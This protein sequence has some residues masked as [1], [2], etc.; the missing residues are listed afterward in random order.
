MNNPV[1]KDDVEVCDILRVFSGDGP[2]R[3]WESGQQRGGNFPCICG[4]KATEYGNLVHCYRHE[5]LD[6]DDRRN[7]VVSSESLK[8]IEKGM[9]SPFQNLKKEEIMDELDCRQIQFSTSNRM[10]LQEKLT[11]TLHG[12]SRP[13]ALMLRNPNMSAAQLNIR[14]YEILGCEP[15]HDISNVIQN[16]ITELPYHTDDQSV[17][18]EFLQFSASTIGEKNQIKGSDARL[19]LVKFSK[20]CSTL[21]IDGHIDNNMMSLVNSLVDIVNI[22]YMSSHLRS[23]KLILR[24]YNQCLIFAVMCRNVIGNPSKMTY[25]KFFGSHYH[26]I[27]THLPEIF[28]LF[29]LRSIFTEQ[30][31]RC[32]GDLRRISEMTTNRQPKY[33]ADNAMLRFQSQY[34][35]DDRLNSF[36]VQDSEI[37]KQ[38]KLLPTPER[39]VLPAIFLTKRQNLVQS[40]LERISDF[41]VCG[42]GIWWNIVDGSIEFNDGP[43]DPSY[44]PEG[45]A[46]NNFRSSSLKK[47]SI[48]L[49]ETWNLAVKQFEKGKLD[50]PLKA[51]KVFDDGGSYK[52][53]KPKERNINNM[54]KG[55]KKIRM[56]CS[57]I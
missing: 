38:S 15:M 20:F 30:E 17:R 28:R 14:S 56:D 49:T 51:V 13:P 31:E 4:I 52:I 47:Q 35:N 24:L 19:Y 22:T 33:I 41:L 32:F 57:K 40:H 39:S 37:K 10:E 46:L 50:L 6:L 21:Y 1:T 36:Q 23:P 44:R 18:K 3:Q 9:L 45:P 53:I 54:S 12:V 48:L 5:E 16:I 25:R 34:K 2:A 8:R 55:N 29:S 26:S 7:L 42:K 11:N 43:N 27:T